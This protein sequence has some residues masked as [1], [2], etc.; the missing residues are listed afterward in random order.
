MRLERWFY[1]VPLRLRSLFR[2]RQ[3][4]QELDEELRYH[5]ERKIEE[6]IGNGLSPAEARYAALRAM[7]G[8]EQRKEECR[9]ARH[10]RVFADLLQDL[11]Y[12][13]RQFRRAPAF[14]LMAVATLALGIGATTAVFSLVN[15]TLLANLPYRD[16]S[17][18]VEVSLIS[19]DNPGNFVVGRE[20][21][22]PWRQSARSCDRLT[23]FFDSG[24][25]LAGGAGAEFPMRVRVASVTEDFFPLLG[26]PAAIGR[27]LQPADFPTSLVWRQG[28]PAAVASI[29]D[30]A[31]GEKAPILISN[32]LFQSRF[33]ANRGLLGQ[34][35]QVNVNDSGAFRLCTVVGVMP[36]DF[37]LPQGTDIW[38]PRRIFSNLEIGFLIAR[39]APG[40]SKDQVRAELD[41]I[42]SSPSPPGTVAPLYRPMPA[43]VFRSKVVSLREYL[44]GNVRTSLL[45]LLGAVGLAMLIACINVTN[46]LLLRH[47]RRR[48][49]TS[50]RAALGAGAAR[51]A[52]QALTE[53]VLLAS[54]GGAAGILLAWWMIRLLPRLAP[55]GLLPER[56]VAL[57][58]RVLLFAILI[59]AVTSL[60]VGLLPALRQP[61]S[62]LSEAIKQAGGH[63]TTT[64]RGV[65]HG[66]LVAAQ[67]ALTLILLCG[68]GLM[69]RSFVL[70]RAAT[71]SFSSANIL[72]FEIS[73]MGFR[74]D[75][76]RTSEAQ[77]KADAYRRQFYEALMEQLRSLPGVKRVGISNRLPGSP[78]SASGTVS[79]Q[80]G[81]VTRI[82]PGYL[83]MLG[84]PLV[85]GRPF[86]AADNQ[87]GAPKVAIIN[88][89]AA[90]SWFGQEDPVA[91][92]FG[93]NEP[94]VIGV[95]ADV[96]QL[97]GSQ[98]ILPEVYVP[99]LQRRPPV[100]L[101]VMV[102]TSHEPTAFV[103]T[104]RKLVARIDPEV[105]VY[106]AMTMQDYV[107]SVLARDRFSTLLL[108]LFA[109]MTLVL[110]AVGIYSVVAQSVEQRLREIAVRMALGARPGQVMEL[111]LVRGGVQIGAGLAVGLLGAIA[112]VRTLRSLLFQV[113]PYDPA[114]FA[115]VLVLLVAVAFLA[116]YGPARRATKVDPLT[117][118]RAE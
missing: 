38:F 90:R 21:Y 89:T 116:C 34:T 47:H 104:I 28:L 39:L 15:A 22:A 83:E 33:G 115:G 9:D 60:L 3:A 88:R 50:V 95:A 44:V 100:D 113:T 117:I 59:T 91:K 101:C 58:A 76:S 80:P 73:V 71:P 7:E 51:L 98:S 17:R 41:S 10:T 26:V 43:P 79:G 27:T 14:A 118:L 48:H 108:T 1:T 46:L 72:K 84:V 29:Y 112:T 70:L 19:P 77:A 42:L 53:S 12:G 64:G 67:I 75:N 92:T 24:S 65:L 103:P 111:V 86:A 18:L 94:V 62:A 66:V 57:D 8:L 110:A 2:N 114:T 93:D 45:V 30:F 31:P 23:A 52:R 37:Q 99:I 85:A 109:V 106:R 87:P 20:A 54:I 5:L 4:E 40:I 56:A 49:E 97:G 61:W 107:D 74:G 69:I 78:T 105:A 36:D 68:A 13:L 32:R 55:Q 6:G 25:T 96:K 81:M 102:E 63:E 16:A 82:T 35:L 11:R